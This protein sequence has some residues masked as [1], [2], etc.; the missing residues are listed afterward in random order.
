IFLLLIKNDQ[1]PKPWLE[2]NILGLQKFNG[3]IEELSLKIS[4]IRTWTYISNHQN[5]IDNEKYW[6]ETTQDIENNLSDKL[7]EGL[8][9]RFVDSTSKYFISLQNDDKNSEFEIKNKKTLVINNIEYGSLIGF[10]LKFNKDVISHSLFSLSHVKKSTRLMI[11]EKINN[12][13]NAPSDSINLG[14]VN[15][16]NIKENIK[17]FWGEENIGQ[18]TRGSSISA[19]M[20]EAINSEYLSSE[21]KLLV[22][23]KLQKWI[24]DLIKTKLWPLNESID[25]KLSSN[26]RAI[27]FNLFESLGT[28][29]I[30]K[31]KNFLKD[32]SQEEKNALSK[33][34]IRIGAKYFFVPNFLKKT[35]MELLSVLWCIFN[36]YKFDGFLPLPKDGRVSFESDNKMQK[37][38]WFAIGYLKLNNFA[39]R[40]DVFERIFF[41]ARQ[42]IKSGPFLD[43]A[44]LM[45]PVG[46][47]RDQLKDILAYC[48]LSYIKFPNE[49]FLFFYESNKVISK[50]K[51]VV[52]KKIDLKS[53]STNK[54]ISK[55]IEKSIDPNSPFAVLEKLL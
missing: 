29:T 17:I 54:K 45:N 38:Y 41:I 34:G 48:G 9:S 2:K 18:L 5:W 23:A 37:G 52:S 6:Q 43:S 31:F 20:A 14:D 21:N 22:S 32:I 40:I 44:D 13:L 47:N 39:L 15:N 7:H 46:C 27:Q 4:Q 8:I 36:E 11:E 16:I 55:K 51:R 19:P 49:R 1:I 3:G 33:L 30:E 12:F 24:D 35:S 50:P 10:D 42:K 53:K 26:V 25:D 28:L